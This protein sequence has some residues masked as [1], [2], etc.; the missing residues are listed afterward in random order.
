[1]TEAK[2]S[3]EPTASPSPHAVEDQLP[4]SRFAPLPPVSAPPAPQPATQKMRAIDAKQP[5]WRALLAW[6]PRATVVRRG[7]PATPRVITAWTQ[8]QAG[9]ACGVLGA[10]AIVTAMVLGWRALGDGVIAQPHEVPIVV[11]G[12]IGRAAIAIAAMVV[13]YG[14]LRIGERLAFPSEK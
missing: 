2:P 4:T 7:E 11:A 5:R 1:M 3:P 14:M 13:G 8:R 10:I 9:L 12:V 6:M